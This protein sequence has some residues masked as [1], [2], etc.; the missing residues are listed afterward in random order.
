MASRPNFG[1]VI[2]NVRLPC[3]DHSEAS[4]WDIACLGGR[5]QSITSS[6]SCIP[7]E[8]AAVIEANGGVLVPSY[9]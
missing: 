5:V 2:R 9:V 4:A 8:E 1:I 3:T 6:G 7:H